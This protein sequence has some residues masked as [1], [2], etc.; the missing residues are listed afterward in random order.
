VSGRHRHHVES[1]QKSDL[2]R[3]LQ[4]AVIVKL[5]FETG[6]SQSFLN[7]F[8][9]RFGIG[10][11]VTCRLEARFRQL[12]RLPQETISFGQYSQSF[13]RRDATEKADR[14]WTTTRFSAVESVRIDPDRH[15]AD[16]FARNPE[17][18]RHEVSVEF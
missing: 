7:L 12:T 11:H 4:N 3:A 17:I 13:F 6:V 2:L 16:L 18:T 15:H 9:V 1:L 5:V 8:E 14:E 10:C